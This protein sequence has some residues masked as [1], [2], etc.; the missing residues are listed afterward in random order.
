MPIA[1]TTVVASRLLGAAGAAP[2]VLNT[3]PWR[4]T[5][6]RPDV[7]DVLADRY[8]WLRVRDPRGRSLHMSCGAALFNLRIAA[9]AMGFEPAVRLLP[10]P[11]C[12]PELL[13][14]VTLGTP[15]SAS[16]PVPVPAPGPASAPAATAAPARASAAAPASASE[17]SAS[18]EARRLYDLIRVRRT[19]KGP[20]A[21]RMIPEAVRA[22]LCAAAALEGAR[23]SFPGERATAD[24]LEHVAAA[25]AELDRDA[26]YQAELAA[27]D[28]SPYVP[29]TDPVRDFGCQAGYAR[30]E[31]RP[32]LAVLT[33]AADTPVDWLRAGQALQHMLLVAAGH[34]ISASYLNQPLDLRDM[35]GRR[36]P[37]HRSGH[38]QMIMRLGYGGIAP[39][40]SRR[41]MTEPIA[42]EGVSGLLQR[43]THARQ[44]GGAEGGVEFGG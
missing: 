42:E 40:T 29:D 18:E 19:T 12:A 10:D 34:A 16:A 7:V 33:T 41:P 23:L 9:Q 1:L 8:R 3:E 5:V 27:W 37:R 21:D 13:A 43:R 35:R 24:L 32:Q 26:E 38:L 36:N 14:R 31:P 2:S 28:P 39:R 11:E 17:A 4:F 22:E 44:D 25:Q 20:F 6:R 30:F 15:A